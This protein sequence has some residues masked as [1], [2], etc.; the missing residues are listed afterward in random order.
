M[1]KKKVDNERKKKW[2]IW[3]KEIR[4]EMFEEK[5]GIGCKLMAYLGIF[6]PEQDNF[7]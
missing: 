6:Y 1:D 7:P 5:K 4:T 3:W 2:K